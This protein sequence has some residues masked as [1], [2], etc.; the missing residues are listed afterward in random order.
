MISTLT[1]LIVGIVV[2]IFLAGFYCGTNAIRNYDD[3]ELLDAID[4]YQFDLDRW[5]DTEGEPG[6]RTYHPS[7]NHSYTTAGHSNV[8]DAIRD[9]VDNHAE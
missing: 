5:T 8:R 9:F 4:Y 1:L 2:V 6:W 7:K 3:T